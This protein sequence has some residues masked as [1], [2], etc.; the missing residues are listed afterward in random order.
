MKWRNGIQ[1]IIHIADAGAHGTEFSEG[2][3]YP[4][5]GKLLPPK[6]EEYVKRN[7]NIIGFKISKYPKKSFDKI[8]EIYNDYKLKNKDFGQFI[9]I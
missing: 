7:I 9:E 3:R 2:D 5:Q 8:S 1:L 6:I 4:E